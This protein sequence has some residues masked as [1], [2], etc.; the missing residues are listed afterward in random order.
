MDEKFTQDRQL[1][2]DP[3]LLQLRLLGLPCI[4]SRLLDLPVGQEDSNHCADQTC[5]LNDHEKL[6]DSV[7]DEINRHGDQ[8]ARC[9]VAQI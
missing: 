7:A 1:E 4:Q 6:V 5:N 3:T 8:Q 9:I 2:V